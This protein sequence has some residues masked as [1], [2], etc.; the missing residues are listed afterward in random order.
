MRPKKRI[1]LIDANE[2]RQ[3]TLR[4]LLDVKGYRVLSASTKEEALQILVAED[5]DC[6]ILR[7]RS[8]CQELTDLGDAL[9]AATRL[10]SG[11]CEHAP[12]LFVS[13]FNDRRADDPYSDQFM[14]GQHPPS[15]LIFRLRILTSRKRGPAKRP[16]ASVIP[17]ALRIKDQE[18]A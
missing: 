10:R 9:K 6:V 16:V 8:R 7:D 15:E 17:D 2:V 11:G 1:L 13:A 5:I 4:Y 12:V 14:W 3:S 18:V